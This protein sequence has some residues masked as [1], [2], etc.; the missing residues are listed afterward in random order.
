[1]DAMVAIDIDDLFGERTIGDGGGDSVP[2][3]QL[4]VRGP[5]LK[6]GKRQQTISREE[7]EK[8]TWRGR[9]L[10]PSASTRY[11]NQ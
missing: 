7:Q 4:D 9:G 3:E 11:P 6:E 10:I 5:A 1:V 8:V 2:K